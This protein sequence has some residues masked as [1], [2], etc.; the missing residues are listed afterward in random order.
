MFKPSLPTRLTFRSFCILAKAFIKDNHFLKC[1]SSPF[2]R[3]GPHIHGLLIHRK[4]FSC[5]LLHEGG[6]LYLFPFLWNLWECLILL[7]QK[8][9]VPNV[10]NC[11]LHGGRWEER[12]G[13]FSAKRQVLLSQKSTTRLWMGIRK[14]STKC[15]PTPSCLGLRCRFW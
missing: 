11:W 14:G 4:A 10:V 12:E 13:S 1:P 9:L 3:L 2:L 6:G 7:W 5:L 15:P 8:H